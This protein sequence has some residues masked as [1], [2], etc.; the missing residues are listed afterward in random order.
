MKI[1]DFGVFL[2]FL[3][4]LLFVFVALTT[5]IIFPKSIIP[6]H[7][8]IAIL[9]IFSIFVI[10][11]MFANLSKIKSMKAKVDLKNIQLETI[12]NNVDITLYLR[13]IDGTILTINQGNAD[14]LGYCVSEIIGQKIQNLIKNIKIIEETDKEVFEKKKILK[15]SCFIVSN[16]GIG[17]HLKIAKIPIIEKDKV[18]KILVCYVDNSFEHEIE[19]TKNEFIETMTHDLKTPTTT[20]IK[21]LELL[22]QGIFGELTEQQKEVINQIKNS[23]IYMNDLIFT[24]LDTYVLE[25]GKIKLNTA[26]IDLS[27]VVNEVINELNWYT[28]EKVRKFSFEVNEGSKNIY[29]DRLQLKRVVFNIISNA[30]KY[31]TPNTEIQ[32]SLKDFSEDKIDFQVRN[33]SEFLT[34]DDMSNIFDKYKT[35]SNSKITKISTGLG[36]Y[37][38]K[39]IIE[40]HHGEIYAKCVDK[41]CIFGFKLPKNPQKNNEE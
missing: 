36:L 37:L 8:G 25:N 4:I 20:Q 7:D 10:Y 26:W 9:L 18:T 32:I 5:E 15:K 1:E 2:S 21:A 29:A 38:S 40:Q 34:K 17:K 13:D 31:G 27:S 22:L 6:I 19:Q 35:K 41:E 33:Q 3:A 39:Q 11:L 30:I 16:K 12:F 23:C 28:K 24:I 14:L